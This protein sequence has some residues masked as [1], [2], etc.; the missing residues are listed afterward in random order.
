MKSEPYQKR[1][2][3]FIQIMSAAE[4]A[5]NLRH[6]DGKASKELKALFLNE[7]ELGL[8]ETPKSGYLRLITTLNESGQLD[9]DIFQTVAKKFLELQ[10]S[11]PTPYLVDEVIQLIRYFDKFAQSGIKAKQV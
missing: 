7:L 1:L 9:E 8:K 3:D 5:K 6:Q 10:E 11:E 4:L 2:G